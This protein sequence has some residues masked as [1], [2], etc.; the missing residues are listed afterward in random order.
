MTTLQRDTSYWTGI[1]LLIVGIGSGIFNSPNTAAMMGRLPP[2]RRGIAAG[3][4][5]LVQNTGAVISIAFVLAIVTAAVPTPVLFAVFSGVANHLSTRR[6]WTRSSPTCTRRCGAC[7][8][9]P[10]SARPSRPPSKSWSASRGAG[11]SPP[12]TRAALT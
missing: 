5:V 8:G 12:E 11:Q 4:R 10:C 2:Q 7:A 1:Y 9:F 6:S 3:A